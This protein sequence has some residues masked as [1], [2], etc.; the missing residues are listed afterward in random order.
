[1]RD[2]LLPH[3]QN[4]LPLS[5]DELRSQVLDSLNAVW[6][7]WRNNQPQEAL[8]LA[9]RALFLS[10]K[11]H[12]TGLQARSIIA[13]A[14]IYRFTYKQELIP[15]CFHRLSELCPTIKDDKD[16]NYAYKA[17]GVYYREQGSLR[18][19]L[20]YLFKAKILYDRHNDLDSLAHTL[21]SLGV[22]LEHSGN[23]NDALRY[24]LEAID[25]QSSLSNKM[26]LA[27]L[28]TNLGA[29]YMRM[30]DYDRAFPYLEQALRVCKTY[31]LPEGAA[32]VYANIG[33]CLL[34][35]EKWQ[36]AMYNIN[37][38]M[39]HWQRLGGTI[40]LP[41]LLTAKGVL[42]I[43]QDNNTE[44][45]K[46]LKK[47]Y[48]MAKSHHN[49]P[50]LI[51]ALHHI[52][53]IQNKLGRKREAISSLCSALEILEPTDYISEKYSI[54]KFL[55]SCYSDNAMYKSAYEHTIIAEAIEKELSSIQQLRLIV[56][57]EVSNTLATLENRYI[58]QQQKIKQA[59]LKV[60]EKEQELHTVTVAFDQNL[61]TL[62]HV[63]NTVAYH[64]YKGKGQAK[65][66]ATT[67]FKEISQAIARNHTR[68]NVKRFDATYREFI[69]KLHRHYPN[70]TPTEIK[71]SV[72]IHL[73]YS[74]KQIADAL[75][76]A[77]L[78]VKKHRAHIRKKLH[79]EGQDN[80]H[81]HLIAI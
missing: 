50:V 76:T 73:N 60:E 27:K 59:E 25:I 58:E 54:H 43:R 66:L 67:I 26:V 16:M 1:M 69:Q 57:T 15:A 24:M 72:L 13:I 4:T 61:K 78:T 17:L 68:H 39:T 21:N 49:I 44:A 23:Y 71:V 74:T 70:L 47:A 79:L 35:Q 20:E 51:K 63:R 42:L 28:L 2:N 34:Y 14:D 64:M 18:L 29:L 22:T 81:R 10:E 5:G 32:V 45:E 38:A 77:E 52:A 46:I 31:A 30:K 19:S 8:S 56:T 36:D 9:N 40:Y 33:E 53:E 11:A 3:T 80:L 12:D 65:E 6:D 62:E 37:K 7:L 48:E 55:S 75:C 41:Q